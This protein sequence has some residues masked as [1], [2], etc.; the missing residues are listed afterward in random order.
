LNNPIQSIYL[1]LLLPALLMQGYNS[2]PKTITKAGYYWQTRFDLSEAQMD[3]LQSLGIRKLYV[4]FFDVIYDPEINKAVPT[5]DIVFSSTPDSLLEIVPVVFIKNNVLQ[6]TSKEQSAVLGDKICR[7][8]KELSELYHLHNIREVQLDCDWTES[9]RDNFFELVKAS[10]AI[11]QQKIISCTIRLHQF[12]YFEKCGVPP[13]NRGMLMFYNM[14]RITT[15]KNYNSIYDSATASGYLRSF[16]KYPLPLDVGLPLFDLSIL[17]RQGKPINT[18]ATHLLPGLPLKKDHG[19][20]YTAERDTFINFTSIRAGDIIKH[21]QTGV[22][23]CMQACR[24]IAPYIDNDSFSVSIF[25]IH[26]PDFFN[27]EKADIQKIYSCFR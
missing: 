14:G 15:N 16:S 19:N 17:F 27:Y 1:L 11:S 23:E 12:K 21:E 13:C 4:R 18:I 6:K 7:R 8:I 24:Q 20:I 10:K 9:T 5:A 3:S 2:H 25:D 22:N 26:Q